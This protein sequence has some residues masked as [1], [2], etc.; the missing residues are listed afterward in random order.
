M[1]TRTKL[2]AA[3]L[4]TATLAACAHQPAQRAPAHPL[5]LD[6][7]VDIP[8]DYMREPRFDVGHDTPLLVDLGKMERGGLDS[9][10]F[11]VY[12]GQGPLTP[13]GYADA[14]A[15]ADRKFSAIALMLEK[16][17]GRIRAARTPQDVRDNQARGV[18]SAMI[19][20]ENRY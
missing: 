17:P 4:A 9:A 2:L 6:T 14:V 18:L 13:K 15:Q 11:V 1:N 20:I 19:G 8:L 5:T 16:Y 10:F 12:V 3:A 7:H